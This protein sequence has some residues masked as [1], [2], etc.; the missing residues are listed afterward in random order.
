MKKE[1]MTLSDLKVNSFVTGTEKVTGGRW[2]I[3]DCPHT[4][5][6]TL[7]YLG[8]NSLNDF[9]CDLQPDTGRDDGFN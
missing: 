6:P 1:K 8:C 5:A 7:D 3:F 2:S 9:Y 4:G